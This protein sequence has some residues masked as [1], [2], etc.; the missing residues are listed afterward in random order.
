MKAH[1]KKLWQ[2]MFLLVGSLSAAGSALGHESGITPEMTARWW[3]WAISIPSSVHPLTQKNT[4]SNGDKYCM[5]GQQGKDW[6]LGGVFKTVDISPASLR[7][8]T[9][10]TPSTA[11]AA[12]T[13]IEI[14]RKCKIIPLGQSILIP[15]INTECNTAEELA[16]GNSVPAD[17]Y[18]KTRYLRHCAKTQADA[19]VP[20]GGGQN[21]ARAYFGPVDYA[22]SWAKRPI[23][24]KRVYTV[25][26]FS[27]TYSED[28]LL[29]NCNDEPFP[30]CV[31]PP[32]P[33]PSLAQADGYWARVQPLKAGTYR[34]QTFGAAPP[35][36]FA[37]R[38]T[39]DLTV[40]APKAQ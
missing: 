33:N 34:L 27:V 2:G 29:K 11:S 35:F 26:P 31:K 9:R 13:P 6:F 36:G 38:V 28:N 20:P 25:E 39:Y 3:Q 22:G 40:V 19:I 1:I 5:V 18:A 10:R 8:Q 21:G 14:N 12:L 37:L 15:V 24:V 23:E 4:D 32:D 17:L 16:L 7:L 30:F